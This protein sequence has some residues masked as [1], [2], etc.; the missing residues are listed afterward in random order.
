MKRVRLNRRAR[1]AFPGSSRG[2]TLIEVVIAML[3][4]GI[5]GVAIL[6]SL[7]YASTV[8]ISVD[9]RATAE[10]LAKSQMEYVKNQPY[11]DINNPPQYIPLPEIPDD[12]DIVITAERLDPNNDGTAND[13]GVQQITVIISYDIVRYNIT[14]RGSEV[15]QKQ[16][17]LEDYKRGPVT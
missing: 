12:Y 16:F 3:L 9:R 1:K 7:S 11:D 4:L 14:T 6:S 10:S 8:L 13:D 5:I 2:F 17:T 15:I